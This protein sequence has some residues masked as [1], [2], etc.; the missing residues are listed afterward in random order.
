M[1][2]FVANFRRPESGIHT[3]EGNVA[4][5]RAAI[6]TKKRQKDQQEFEDKKRKIANNTKRGSCGMD[7]KFA[8]NSK[9]SV[10]EQQ[11]RSTTIGL[12]TAEEFKRASRVKEREAELLLKN[13][14]PSSKELARKAKAARKAKKKRLKEERKMIS[15]L[16][17]TSENYE[18]AFAGEVLSSKSLKDPHIDT[19]FLP[20]KQ[21]E[22]DNER[23]RN[24]L[25]K[26]WKENQ[27]SVKREVLEIVYSYWDGSGH[28]RNVKCLKG[29]TIGDFLELVRKD[30]CKEFRELTAISGDALMYVKEDLIIPQDLSFYDLIV[31][32]ARG[33]S[34]P[35]FHFDVHEDLRVG[36]IDS[37]V[38]KDESHPGKVIERSW[39]DRNKHIFPASRWEV[40]DPQKLYGKYTIHGN[41]VN[42]RKYCV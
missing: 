2:D 42:K 38:E 35:L 37:R 5:S 7:D 4:G 40:F 3:V 24:Q 41:E 25:E 21:R 33:K 39:Y 36:A 15:T 14:Q 30:L 12:V 29:N 31:T 11:F 6:L 27:E 10:S 20:D 8:K 32:K 18:N 13:A 28:R 17:F 22:E 19:S 1:G 34:G 26:E 23:E 9:V 16:S